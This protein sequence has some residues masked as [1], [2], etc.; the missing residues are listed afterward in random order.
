VTQDF[1][2]MLGAGEVFGGM[3]HGPELRLPRARASHDPPDDSP[4]RHGG[5]G[6]LFSS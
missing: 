4:F 1:V 6:K 3:A 2:G 5:C